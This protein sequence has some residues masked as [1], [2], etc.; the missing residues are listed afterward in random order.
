MTFVQLRDQ[1]IQIEFQV[2]QPG[3]ALGCPGSDIQEWHHRKGHNKQNFPHEF[4]PLEKGLKEEPNAETV[5]AP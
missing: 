4:P 2:R 1:R 5:T 3:R